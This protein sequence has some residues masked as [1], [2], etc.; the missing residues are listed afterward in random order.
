M[1]LTLFVAGMLVLLP[2]RAAATAYVSEQATENSMDKVRRE[3]P[4]RIPKEV[5]EKPL[6][7]RSPN[8]STNASPQTKDSKRK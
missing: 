7:K 2:G 5:A 6:V 3:T 8:P 1:K 4:A